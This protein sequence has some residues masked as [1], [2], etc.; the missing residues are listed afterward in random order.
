MWWVVGGVLCCPPSCMLLTHT[1][2]PTVEAKRDHLMKVFALYRNQEQADA[3][4]D[5]LG[6]PVDAPLTLS[7][8]YKK[9]FNPV[10][11]ANRRVAEVTFPGKIM[12]WRM[13]YLVGLISLAIGNGW[14]LHV[15]QTQSVPKMEELLGGDTALLSVRE[16]AKEVV[17]DWLAAANSGQE[18]K[19]GWELNA[20]PRR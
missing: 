10:D 8:H 19:E 14:A 18:Q 16:Y 1:T 9:N 5:A 6:T 4:L 13:R 17:Q 2:G 7:T 11:H 20:V 12:N 15:E 3:L